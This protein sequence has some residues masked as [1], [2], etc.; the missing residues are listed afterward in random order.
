MMGIR[1]HAEALPSISCLKM[2]RLSSTGVHQ[3]RV[4]LS[5]APLYGSS[6]QPHLCC[7]QALCSHCQQAG[8]GAHAC[9]VHAAGAA[10]QH[11]PEAGGGRWVRYRGNAQ[12][13]Q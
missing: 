11:L 10:P 13:W 2:T 3:A 12:S 1:A 5:L 4:H 9:M 7:T 8:H 6:A